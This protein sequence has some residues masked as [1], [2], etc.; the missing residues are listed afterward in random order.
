MLWM[1]LL[2]DNGA[3]TIIVRITAP[4]TIAKARTH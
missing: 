2:M 4:I 1:I 3:K